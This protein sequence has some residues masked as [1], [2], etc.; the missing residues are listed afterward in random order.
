MGLDMYLYRKK[1]RSD[2]ATNE[3]YKQANDVQLMY[4]RKAN[5]IHSWFTQGAEEDNC[6][7][8]PV[9]EKDILKLI[10]L[11]MD[12]L[13]DKDDAKELLPTSRGFFWGDTEYNEYYYQDITDT[14]QGLSEALDDIRP[15]DKLYYYA[16]Y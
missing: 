4:W 11:C 7:P 8:I 15:N 6:T 16:W 9:T 10:D 2:Y 13:A 3:D 5:Q 12:V 14:I 1:R